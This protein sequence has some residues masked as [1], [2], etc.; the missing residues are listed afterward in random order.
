VKALIVVTDSDAVPAFERA[1]LESGQQGFTIVPTVWGRGRT[2]LKAGDRVHP[3]GSSLLFTVVPDGEAES[4]LAFLRE[5]R[6]R[7]GVTQSTKLF[8]APVDGAY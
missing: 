1:L 3:G 6:D 5:V 7:T 2:G 4:A 8:V